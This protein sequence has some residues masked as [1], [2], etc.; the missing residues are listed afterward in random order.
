MTL[1]CSME[2][3]R[4]LQSA[5]EYSSTLQIFCTLSYWI[6]CTLFNKEISDFC[7]HILQKLTSHMSPNHEDS[8]TDPEKAPIFKLSIDELEEFNE[9]TG[10]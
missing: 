3:S 7:N 9:E 1:K 5:L 4:V 8:H 2:N 10:T 6:I